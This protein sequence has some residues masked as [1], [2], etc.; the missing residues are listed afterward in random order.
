MLNSVESRNSGKIRCGAGNGGRGNA[1]FHRQTLSCRILSCKCLCRSLYCNS[2]TKQSTAD[3]CA[4]TRSDSLANLWQDW[5]VLQ[6]NCEATSTRQLISLHAVQGQQMQ[7][8]QYIELLPTHLAHIICSAR[9]GRLRW[10]AEHL[11]Q[12]PGGDLLWTSPECGKQHADA[13][14]ACVHRLTECTAAIK[15]SAKWQNMVTVMAHCNIDL[16][17]EG[18]ETCIQSTMRMLW[19]QADMS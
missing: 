14:N 6:H 8:A 15:L 17:A 12:H 16:T 4:E 18:A 11:R 3:L 1:A 5:Q 7:R 13:G 9:S 10:L 2:S 19:P